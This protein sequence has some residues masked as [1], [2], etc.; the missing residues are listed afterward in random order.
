MFSLT[1]IRRLTMARA[2]QTC[3]AS[4]V[5]M[6]KVMTRYGQLK[7]CGGCMNILVP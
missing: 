1:R 6:L 2:S 4:W 7:V 5:R 3:N